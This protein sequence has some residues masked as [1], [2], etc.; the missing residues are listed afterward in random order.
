[1]VALIC[2]EYRGYTVL[3]DDHY[4]NSAPI[5]ERPAL[6]TPILIESPDGELLWDHLWGIDQY[7]RMQKAH[8]FID[9]MED[10]AEGEWQEILEALEYRRKHGA[11]PWR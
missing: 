8:E 10:E 11:G 4:L 7:H 2:T 5:A 6:A 1:M 3:F 9:H